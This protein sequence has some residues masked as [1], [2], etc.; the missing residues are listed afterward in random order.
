MVCAAYD[1]GIHS[2]TS[3]EPVTFDATMFQECSATP[4]SSSCFSARTTGR[5]PP[6]QQ[7]PQNLC[8]IAVSTSDG[9]DWPSSKFLSGW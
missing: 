6:V 7:L 4:R 5:R 1:T 2:T 8:R 3:S 9:Q